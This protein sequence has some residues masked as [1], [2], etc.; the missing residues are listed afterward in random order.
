M[1][2]NNAR[3][4]SFNTSSTKPRRSQPTPIDEELERK[5]PVRITDDPY[6]LDGISDDNDYDDDDYDDFNDDDD[7]ENVD[8]ILNRMLDTDEPRSIDDILDDMLDD[9]DSEDDND[10]PL[11]VLANLLKGRDSEQTTSDTNSD[12]AYS[13]WWDGQWGDGLESFSSFFDQD[14]EPADVIKSINEELG[15]KLSTIVRNVMSSTLDLSEAQMKSFN[16]TQKAERAVQQKRTDTRSALL[17]EMSFIKS[18]A[19]KVTFDSVFDKVW[20]QTKGDK[21]KTASFILKIY[22]ETH[23]RKFRNNSSASF[24]RPKRGTTGKTRRGK[25]NWD[26]LLSS[27]L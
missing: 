18:R 9:D 7:D 5:D 4:E 12:D 19:D 21:R 1:L 2:E 8:D 20:Q 24:S 15:T 6:E 3:G 13:S 26:D 10:D 16:E 27:N 25:Q 14:A 11:S 23:S 17:R 22:R